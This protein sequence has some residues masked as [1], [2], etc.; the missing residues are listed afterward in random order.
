MPPLQTL[1]IDANN[2]I[3]G[4]SLNDYTSNA[5][6]SPRTKGINPL[7]VPGI[8]YP[9]PPFTNIENL[10]GNI[11][12][13]I[14]DP[15]YLG[16]DAYILDDE[17][18][19][20]TLS[21]TTLTK[22]Q[23]DA[24]YSYIKGSSDLIFFN[25]NVFATSATNVALL[26]GSNL[27]T[28]DEDW[29]TATRGHGSL[30]VNYRHP[31]EVVEDTLYIADQN[32]LH[33]WDGTTSVPSALVLPNIWNITCLK[34]HPNGRDLIAFCAE[35]AN[36]SNQKGTRAVAFIINTVTLEFTQ[37]IIIGQQV[38][39]ARVV[40]GIM[41]VTY[42]QNLGYF[43]ESGIVFLRKLNVTLFGGNLGYK[44]HLAD[45]DG[46]LLVI[47]DTAVLAFGDL[48]AGKVFWY[49]TLNNT[50]QGTG[51]NLDS[52]LYIGSGCIIF[53]TQTSGGVEKLFKQDFTSVTNNSNSGNCL[54]FYTNLM[55]F[56]SKVW[57]RRVEIYHTPLISGHNLY[58][59]LED[60][61][62]NQTVI[63]YAEY[64]TVGSQTMTRVDCNY[65][66]DIARLFT[67]FNVNANIALPAI[68][69]M[70]IYYEQAET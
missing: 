18:K 26:T 57:I 35:T 43:T 30:Q 39:G 21:G 13:S 44:H 16:N 12:A 11:V 49:P 32:M 37:E 45:M 52:I 42:G 36:Y 29:W 65:Y 61:N 47:E 69:K 2:L 48:G 51:Q 17:G 58:V 19:Y 46:H 6:Y 64:A 4:A 54:E 1:V 20:Y 28:L 7:K 66:A 27:S 38:E 5:G 31:M 67:Y 70:I 40:A 25:G 41:Y 22:R 59:R 8:L 34:K 9:Q 10:E 33:T 55:S 60:D 3:Q 24:T 63:G 56:P 15:N 53:G 23:T 62:S 14:A 68:K 50:I